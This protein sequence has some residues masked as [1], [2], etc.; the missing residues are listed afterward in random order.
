M[1]T[2]DPVDS[3]NLRVTLETYRKLANDFSNHDTILK[4]KKIDN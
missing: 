4:V 2:E 1:E 3:D